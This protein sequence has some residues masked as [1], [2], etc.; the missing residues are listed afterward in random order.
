MARAYYTIDKRTILRTT[1]RLAHKELDTAR[2]TSGH[3]CISQGTCPTK[4]RKWIKS[5]RYISE[6]IFLHSR[7][8]YAIDDHQLDVG[9]TLNWSEALEQ[10]KDSG[11]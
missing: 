4:R 10:P 2:P 7:F 9:L 6:L 1:D 3:L 11:A 8:A 5:A